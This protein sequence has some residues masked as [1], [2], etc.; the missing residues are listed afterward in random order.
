MEEKQDKSA[1]IKRFTKQVSLSSQKILAA[2]FDDSL[3]DK[4]KKEK[5]CRQLDV[6]IR[7]KELV[8]IQ[9]R[10]TNSALPE[11]ETVAGFVYRNKN[12]PAQIILRSLPSQTLRMIAIKD[13][14]KVSI[15]HQRIA[16]A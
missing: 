4:E 1:N 13:I 14:L 7:N 10:L 16:R 5:I 3:K 11:F 2:F 15:L 6:A 12:S 9:L 8:V